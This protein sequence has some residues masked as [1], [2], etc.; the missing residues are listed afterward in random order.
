MSNDHHCCLL[1]DYVAYDYP[2]KSSIIS[3]VIEIHIHSILSVLFFRLGFHLVLSMD[4]V[5]VQVFALS[6]ET[7][8]PC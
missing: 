1:L 8:L 7:G 5:N 2:S 6:C 4:C 3:F